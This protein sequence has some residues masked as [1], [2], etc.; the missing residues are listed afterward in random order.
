MKK[1]E[2]HTVGQ[3]KTIAKDRGIRCYYKLIKAELIHAVEATRLVEQK[4]HIFDEPIP[5]DLTPVLQPTPW[6]RSNI[7]TKVKQNINNFFTMDMQKIK[8]FGE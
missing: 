3:L 6:R 2:N 8:Y 7:T 4:S 1:M 5:N